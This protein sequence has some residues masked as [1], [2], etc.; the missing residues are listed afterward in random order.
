[1]QRSCYEQ[2]VLKLAIAYEGYHF[3]LPAFLDFRG[4]IY[5]SGILH[6][7]E[8]DLARS[9]VVFADDA[10][11]LEAL[12][13]SDHIVSFIEATSFHY[14][15][16]PNNCVGRTWFKEN[17]L[18]IADDNHTLIEKA[19]DAKKPIQLL[20]C[21]AAI[22]D[23]DG[24]DKHDSKKLSEI[25][26]YPITQDASTS[27][28][29]LMSYFLLDK[30]LALQTNLIALDKKED[31]IHDLYDYLLAD[32]KASI[33]KDYPNDSL[34]LSV[35]QKL[36]HSYCK[37]N[38]VFTIV[39]KDNK[40]ITYN[41]GQ[42]IPLTPLDGST[43]FFPY[44]DIFRY[45]YREV[46]KVFEIYE[47][48]S[49]ANVSL[50][51]FLTG[52]NIEKH[53][54]T[55]EVIKVLDTLFED[56]SHDYDYEYKDDGYVKQLLLSKVFSDKARRDVKPPVAK[57]IVNK[58]R[59]YSSNISQIDYSN[60]NGITP[61]M[62]ADIETILISDD[63][64]LE[65]QT[66]YAAGLL[67]VLPEKV[68]DKA[69]IMTFYSEGYIYQKINHRIYEIK[70]YNK[71]QHVV[72]EKMVAK[73]G[74]LL[75]TF[76]DSLNLLP[77]KLATL[78]RNLCP[79]LKDKY[80]INHEQLKTM[81]DISLREKELLEYLKQDV[82]TASSLAMRIFRIKY[83]DALS[84]PIHIPNVNEDNFITRGYYGGH[85][86]VYKSYGENLFY[87]DVNS[88]YPYVM[89]KEPMPAHKPV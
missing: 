24:K 75:F 7:H 66:S 40:E 50:R 42:A 62:V 86:D 56:L 6:F 1:M 35:G 25:I 27:A 69:D 43:L 36:T 63:K 2:Y 71:M 59:T 9:L 21:V 84:F 4:R 5:R 57:P 37:F 89:Q 33:V 72:D 76:K 41:P 74:V 19:R 67:V 16:F 20:S 70:V 60:S 22:N 83:Y 48:F 31:Y 45:I 79:D 13:G 87:Y 58:K 61:F 85:V 51:V 32:L 64:G 15:G 54:S 10:F 47:D 77:G 65:V 80:D 52:P 30:V 28:Y 68:L 46:V 44:K 14:K 88:L 8:R 78:A 73:K 39:D 11:S 53:L 26:Y 3:Y 34:I 29:Q 82:L 18:S 81:E 12:E 49:I 17:I 55:D 23:Y 38:M